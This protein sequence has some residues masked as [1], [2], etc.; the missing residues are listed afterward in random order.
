M[1]SE[2]GMNDKPNIIVLGV[3]NPYII[4]DWWDPEEMLVDRNFASVKNRRST[5]TEWE[6]KNWNTT[7]MIIILILN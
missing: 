4:W 3:E 1:T 7:W 6:Q 2:A 5:N